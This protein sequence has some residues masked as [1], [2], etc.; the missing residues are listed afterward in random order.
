LRYLIEH[1]TR[2]DFQ[3]PVQEH[4][5]ETRLMPRE[6]VHQRVLSHR[7]EID[8]PATLSSYTD[9]FGNKVT[10]FGVIFPHRHLIT[11]VRTEVETFLENPFDYIPLSAQDE[12]LWYKAELKRRPELRRYVLHQSLATPLFDSLDLTDLK[13]PKRDLAEPIQASLLAAMQWIHETLAYRTGSTRVDT[14]MKEALQARAGVCQDFAHLMISLVRSWNVP[15]RYVMGY[16]RGSVK[17]YDD[18]TDEEATH[19]WA[20]VL[21]P[22]AGWR[23]FDPTNRLCTNHLY[24]PVAVGR[25]YMDAAPQRGTFKGSA[26]PEAPKVRVILQEQ[27]L[28]DAPPAQQQEQVAQ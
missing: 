6:D 27:S 10:Y 24:I 7:M 14:P 26:V 18:S 22:G 21:I 12:T 2:L 17:G 25:D 1:E 4:H 28:Q 20:E 16:M 15:A 13:P 8:P 23:G 11:R 19:A 9:A 3:V 5:C